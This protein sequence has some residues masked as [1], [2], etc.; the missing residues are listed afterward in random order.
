M[1][2]RWDETEVEPKNEYFIWLRS[3]KILILS[4]LKR[5]LIEVIILKKCLELYVNVEQSFNFT[6]I[7]YCM[8]KICRNSFKT[9]TSIHIIL[10]LTYFYF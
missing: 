2:T 8:T 6:Y 4:W 1:I 7:L 5:H 10:F 9:D 3:R